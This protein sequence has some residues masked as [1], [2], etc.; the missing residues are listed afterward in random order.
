M[1]LQTVILSH[2]SAVSRVV[3]WYT[4]S[5]CT[6]LRLIDITVHATDDRTSITAQLFNSTHAT[7][8]LEKNIWKLITLYVKFLLINI[9]FLFMVLFMIGFFYIVCHI[10]TANIGLEA[11]LRYGN[12][13]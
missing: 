5:P 13:Q 11:L 10:I 4:G 6:T 8:V 7:M 2:S 1:R 12:S 3:D 9:S